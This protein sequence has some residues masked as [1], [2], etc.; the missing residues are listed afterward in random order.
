MAKFKLGQAVKVV[1]GSAGP[2]CG[3]IAKVE[4]KPQQFY[5]VEATDKDGRTFA[6]TVEESW[7]EADG[8]PEESCPATAFQ[9]AC[10]ASSLKSLVFSIG[11]THVAGWVDEAERAAREGKVVKYE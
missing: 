4:P 11:G 10:L 3:Y 9:T 7:L 2:L 1:H 5:R 8:K 6:M